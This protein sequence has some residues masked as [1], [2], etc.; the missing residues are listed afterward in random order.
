MTP[1]RRIAKKT[2]GGGRI[3]TYEGMSQQIYSLPP[4]AAWVPLRQMSRVFSAQR[5]G[6]STSS[7]LPL[8]RLGRRLAS[9][10]WV[11]RLRAAVEAREQVGFPPGQAEARHQLARVGALLEGQDGLLIGTALAAG[12]NQP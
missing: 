3:R 12:L 9:S 6:V 11:R 1:H 4:L 2:G 5:P 10:R 8:G 7:A